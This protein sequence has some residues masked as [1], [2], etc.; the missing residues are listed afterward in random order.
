MLSLKSLT[1]TAFLLSLIVDGV[2]INCKTRSPAAKPWLILLKE[3]EI[4]FALELRQFVFQL[5]VAKENKA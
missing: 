4:A 2:S 5:N 3:S 1:L